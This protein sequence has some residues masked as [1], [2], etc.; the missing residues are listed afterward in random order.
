M[1]LSILSSLKPSFLRP[2][3]T[4]KRRQLHRT[5]YLDGLRG[6]AAL[7]VVFAHYEATYFPSLDLA[8]HAG[9]VVGVESAECQ[10]E[11]SVL[12]LPIVRG[13]Y[14][15]PFMVA[16]FFVISGHVLSQKALGEFGYWSP[17]HAAGRQ[18]I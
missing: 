16:I 18:L 12:Q 2:A 8:W 17:L 4:A 1:V 6:V 13:L 14:N 7:F 3:P 5:S 9:C 15:G 11:S 10:Q